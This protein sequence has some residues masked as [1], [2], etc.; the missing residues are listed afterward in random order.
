M[1]LLSLKRS[2]KI[3]V[4]NMVR[5]KLLS[6]STIVIMGLI[7]FIFN[8][9]FT[10][11]V[12][13]KENIKDIKGKVDLILYLKEDAD[14]L[15]VNRF[16]SDL[17]ALPEVKKVTYTT[18]DEALE[19]LLAQYSD[20]INPFENYNLENPLPGSI[21]IITQTPEEHQKVLETIE[22]SNYTGLLMNTDSNNEGQAIANRLVVI[23]Q[24][25][26]KLLWGILVAFIIGSILVIANTLH[27]NIFHKQKEIEIMKLVGAPLNFIRTPF[28]IEGSLYGIGAVL[29]SL[30][31]L[32]LFSTGINLEQTGLISIHVRYERLIGIE[33][34]TAMGIGIMSSLLALYPLLIRK[35]N[36]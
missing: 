3:A 2:V 13:A 29:L 14:A 32:F 21:Q 26:E 10:V 35:K 33:L 6:T 34:L 8:I 30:I 24:F 1:N 18:K 20:T 15:M 9:I 25:T 23:T 11:N 17:E 5:N 22:T 16:L 4:D 31:L 28:M 7:L 12:I 27:I 19:S 36:A